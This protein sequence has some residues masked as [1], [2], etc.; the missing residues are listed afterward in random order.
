MK[1]TQRLGLR[2]SLTA[3]QSSLLTTEQPCWK[4]CSLM[5]RGSLS[6]TL[7][8]I[9]CLMS[10]RQSWSEKL[11][12]CSASTANTALVQAPLAATLTHTQAQYRDLSEH[13]K[14]YHVKYTTT[15]TSWWFQYLIIQVVNWRYFDSHLLL[16]DY[17]FL[18]PVS[19]AVVWPVWCNSY[20]FPHWTPSIVGPTL[21]SA[22]K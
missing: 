15:L 20:C 18:P 13:Y 22:W 10:L 14:T 21:C 16:I 11:W 3:D 19:R 17:S 1:G 8:L 7:I 12:R 2:K 5:T 4:S 9:F 6:R